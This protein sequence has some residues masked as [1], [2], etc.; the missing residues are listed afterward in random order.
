MFVS[1][2]RRDGRLRFCL[3]NT[4]AGVMQGLEELKV[5]TARGG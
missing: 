4:S 2:E 1:L 3:S 5:G